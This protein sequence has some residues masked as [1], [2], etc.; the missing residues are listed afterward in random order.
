MP[1]WESAASCLKI[2]TTTATGEPK[3]VMEEVLK[4]DGKEEIYNATGIQFMP[5]NTLYQFSAAQA[6]DSRR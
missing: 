1:C 4:N 5:I 3:G 2:L 6:Q